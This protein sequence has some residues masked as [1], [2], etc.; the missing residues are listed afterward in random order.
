MGKF[1]EIGVTYVDRD[2]EPAQS[3]TMGI[4]QFDVDKAAFAEPNPLDQKAIA[5]LR[6]YLKKHDEEVA[7]FEKK[8]K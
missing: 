4:L 3:R 5:V 7:A 8:L 2:V 6:R 1:I